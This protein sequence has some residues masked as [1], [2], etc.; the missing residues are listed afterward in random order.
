MAR[1]KTTQERID[2]LVALGAPLETPGRE[3]VR[4]W[5]GGERSEDGT[6]SWPYPEYCDDVD[7]F[8][9]AAEAPWWND[10]TY[11]AVALGEL[12]QDDAYI[13][14]ATLAQIKALLTFCVRGE[15]FGDGH[16][17]A[18]LKAGRINA[19]LRRLR[20]LRVVPQWK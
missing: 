2:H 7:A 8:F 9:R 13:A 10:Y 19:I 5:C 6:I 1:T 18:L 14:R 11:D 15:R 20:D 17:E 16:R 12:M 4:Q 3:F